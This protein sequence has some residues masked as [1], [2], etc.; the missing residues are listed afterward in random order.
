MDRNRSDAD[1]TGWPGI[2]LLVP[3]AVL[4]GFAEPPN[5]HA[6]HTFAGAHPLHDMDDREIGVLVVTGQPQVDGRVVCVLRW[7]PALV[8]E[9][10]ARAAF[11]RLLEP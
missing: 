3:S 7:D 9:V 5:S 2:R 10:Q 11:T 6:R 1:S 4:A 8:N